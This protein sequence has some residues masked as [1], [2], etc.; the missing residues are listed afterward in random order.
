MQSIVLLIVLLCIVL[1]YFI[2]SGRAWLICKFKFYAK[3][4]NMSRFVGRYSV[5]FDPQK[6][7]AHFPNLGGVRMTL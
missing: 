5:P 6:R 4:G 7:R 2:L 1:F 3:G